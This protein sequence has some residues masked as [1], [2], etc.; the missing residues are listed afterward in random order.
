MN[1]RDLLRKLLQSAPATA[2]VAGAAASNIDPK[3]D[4]ELDALKEA[5][6]KA[7]GELDLWQVMV[8]PCGTW[9][10]HE[11][12]PIRRGAPTMR[13]DGRDEPVHVCAH[14]GCNAQVPG[15]FVQGV[16]DLL[17]DC[18]WDMKEPVKG[19]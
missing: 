12:T 13:L 10:F 18:G 1:R 11:W 6:A 15:V 16:R 3:T 17:M 8:G 19:Q 5:L 2:L 7:R 4:E 9:G 14:D